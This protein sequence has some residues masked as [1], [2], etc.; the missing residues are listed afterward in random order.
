M[1]SKRAKVDSQGHKSRSVEGSLRSICETDRLKL[2]YYQAIANAQCISDG[3][4]KLFT[5]EK[6]QSFQRAQKKSLQVKDLWLAAGSIPK[7]A[8]QFLR[9]HEYG[10]QACVHF[11][12]ERLFDPNCLPANEETEP[13]A[14]QAANAC[15][16]DVIVVT[17]GE[18]VVSGAV[19]RD[20]AEG[21]SS[22]DH[23]RES[24]E[25]GAI[26][27][28]L[29]EY[30]F[31]AE[32]KSD[33]EDAQDLDDDSTVSK[34]DAVK[35]LQKYHASSGNTLSSLDTFLQ[36]AHRLKPDWDYSKLPKRA[37]DV[38]KV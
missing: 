31:I 25:E 10:M 3:S 5:G 33:D 12:I 6:H 35:F 19:G 11:G 29:E 15:M 4:K 20:D 17:S 24:D 23:S 32:E 14:E 28:L 34:C 18:G 1:S 38:I 27:S 22:Q 7:K 21:N 2:K 9:T 26:E 16:E 8:V 36:L 13:S 30:L 37:K